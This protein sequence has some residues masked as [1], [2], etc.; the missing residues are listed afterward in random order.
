MLFRLLITGTPKWVSAALRAVAAFC[1]EADSLA[2]GAV[3][4]M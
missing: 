1:D 4:A 2:A 3:C